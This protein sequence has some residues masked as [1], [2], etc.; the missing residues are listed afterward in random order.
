YVVRRSL[1]EWST[2]VAHAEEL[3]VGDHGFDAVVAAQA[4]HWFDLDRALPEIAR[5]LKRGGR[6]D[7]VWNYRDDSIPWIR[8][9]GAII[10]NQEQLAD[11]GEALYASG[12]FGSVEEARFT[13]WQQVDRKSIQDLVLSRS[14]I[15]VLDG[16]ARAAQLAEVVAFYDDYGRGMDGMQL[17]YVTRCFRATVVDQPGVDDPDV[18]A[19]DSDDPSDGTDTD[20]LLIDF[21]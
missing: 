6:L 4:F 18:E 20:M 14:N 12:L 15:A 1:Q 8:R 10:G 7:L 17:P 19:T 16:E 9:L 13:H 2:L 3:P 5:A 11:P 21:R